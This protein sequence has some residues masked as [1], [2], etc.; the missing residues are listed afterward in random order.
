MF[1]IKKFFVD[2]DTAVNIPLDDTTVYTTCLFCGD[3]IET[4]LCDVITKDF[5]VYGTNLFC[6]KCNGL[7]KSI[8]KG[9]D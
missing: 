9:E 6:N 2:D 5:D 3:E 7:Y 1:Y 8:R 4:D